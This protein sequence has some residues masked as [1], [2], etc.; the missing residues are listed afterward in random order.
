MPSTS[1]GVSVMVAVPETGATGT[2]V[3]VLPLSSTPSSLMT[4]T[5]AAAESV[6]ASLAP[7]MLKFTATAAV[8]PP[9]SITV[10]VKPSL[11]RSSTS[12]AWVSR[13]ALSST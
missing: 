4:P 7:T 13:S 1:P 6:G 8:R 9:A 5:W 12:R 2:V 3:S 11:T 10:T